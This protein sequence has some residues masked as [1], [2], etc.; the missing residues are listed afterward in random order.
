M[1]LL[2]AAMALAPAAGEFFLHDLDG[3]KRAIRA[4]D[5]KATVVI[6][7]STVCPVSQEYERRYAALFETYAPRGVQF[8]FAYSNRNESIAE[9]RRH[10]AEFSFPVYRDEGQTVADLFAARVTP[11]A[12]LLDARGELVYRGRFDDSTNPVRVK[13]RSLENA[14]RVVLAG[15]RPK[16]RETKAFG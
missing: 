12:V 2:A 8:A 5:A 4:A 10:S 15:K 1:I 14:I 3:T 11:T 16:V 7:V 13:D 6:F 9:I